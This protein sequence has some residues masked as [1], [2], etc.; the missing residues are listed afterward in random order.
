VQLT[1]M[2][3]ETEQTREQLGI[4]YLANGG[5]GDL[6]NTHL[7]IRRYIAQNKPEAIISHSDEVARKAVRMVLKQFPP[8]EYNPMARVQLDE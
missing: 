1:P 6:K 4:E 8:T 2:L 5:L 3:Y 7:M